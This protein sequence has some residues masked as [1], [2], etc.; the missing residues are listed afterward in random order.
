MDGSASL[1]VGQGEL[2]A[3]GTEGGGFLS[4]GVDGDGEEFTF[5]E[6]GGQP[7]R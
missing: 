2:G 3:K 4:G 7:T 1:G 5:E 6:R